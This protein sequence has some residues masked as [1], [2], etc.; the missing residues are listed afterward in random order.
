MLALIIVI[1]RVVRFR[2]GAVAPLMAV[3]FATP[4]ILFHQYVG[5]DELAYRV[6]ELDYGPRARRFEPVQDVTGFI[7]NL[8]T[9][10]AERRST[11]D[12]MLEAL[13]SERPGEYIDVVKQRISTRVLLEVLRDRER[14][15]SECRDFIADHPESRFVPNVL[16]IQ[17]LALDTRLDELRFFGMT[18][19]FPACSLWISGPAL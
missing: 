6:L 17:A 5:V 8:L 10:Q 4:M 18:R 13:S 12:W 1:A 3:M 2:P 19:I 16:Y 9:R 14:A 7:R 11:Q 15:Y